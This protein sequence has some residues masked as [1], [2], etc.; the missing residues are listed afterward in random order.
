MAATVA[1]TP[2]SA[3][4]F[5]RT[6]T[7]ADLDGAVTRARTPRT[8][9]NVSS[10]AERQSTPQLYQPDMNR[11]VTALSNKLIN[12]INYQT[13]LDDSLVAARLELEAS[14][15]RIR[16]LEAVNGE[17]EARLA[18]GTW[19]RRTEMQMEQ[20]T[21]QDALEEERRQRAVVEREKKGIEQELE[22]L[23][24]ALFEEANQV[25]RPEPSV[26]MPPKRQSS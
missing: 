12:A 8:A 11:E 9:S 6:S 2:L 4:F 3:P 5:T 17:H 20:E 7:A 15:D 24:T 26:P 22:N 16:Q 14:R 19:V 25:R 1:P 13:N 18:D 23:T 21:L 10:T